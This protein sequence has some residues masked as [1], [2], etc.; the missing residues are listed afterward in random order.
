VESSAENAVRV[1]LEHAGQP[2]EEEG[3]LA[4][5]RRHAKFLQEFLHPEPFAMTTFAADGM[6]EMVVQ[7][8]IHFYALCEHHLVPFFGEAVV[9]YIPDERIVGLSKLARTVQ[10]VSRQRV[11]NQERI[12]QHVGRHLE[13][14]LKPKGVG[15]VL[16][17][18]HLCM[19]MRGA[20][21]FGAVTT[22]SYLS[23]AFREDDKTRAEFL[24]L[25]Q[26]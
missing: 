16:R 22:T 1:L 21:T 7:S 14:H 18:R 11:Q 20:R 26:K 19:E 9:A 17:A 15:V 12:T 25:A 24:N 13:E 23:G 2:T 8:G 6:S 5:P 3:L 4:T 10:F